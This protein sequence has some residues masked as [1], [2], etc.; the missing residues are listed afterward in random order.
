MRGA[1]K[2]CDIQRLY[3]DI[4]CGRLMSVLA[5]DVKTFL[6]KLK[7]LNLLSSTASIKDSHA[8]KMFTYFRGRQRNF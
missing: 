4:L 2:L 5:F 7:K 8:E 1:G 3:G 6:S